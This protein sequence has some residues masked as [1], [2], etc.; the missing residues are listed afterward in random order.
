MIGAQAFY[1]YQAGHL[2]GWDLNA[3]ATMDLA[4]QFGS[5]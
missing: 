3:Q 1:E 2:A 5:R 4:E